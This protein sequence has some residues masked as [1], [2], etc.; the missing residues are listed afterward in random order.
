MKYIT[1]IEICIYEIEWIKK[2]FN[3]IIS[4][5]GF[6]NQQEQEIIRIQ[7]T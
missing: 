1:Q 2:R 4:F 5:Y 3:D 6:V 7:W